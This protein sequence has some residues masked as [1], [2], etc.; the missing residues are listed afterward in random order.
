MLR[1]FAVQAGAIGVGNDQPGIAGK[2]IV[3]Q[4]ARESEEQPI[5]MRPI[6]LPFPVRTQILGRGF[7]LDDP[8]LAARVDSDQIGPASGRQRQFAEAGKSK[9]S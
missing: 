7:D 5:A 8:D 3:R 2:N 6:V 1:R 9:R 4:V